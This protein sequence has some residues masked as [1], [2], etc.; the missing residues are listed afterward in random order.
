MQFF[1]ANKLIMQFNVDVQINL[2][3]KLFS[4]TEFST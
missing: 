3:A 1:I 4:R 2:F